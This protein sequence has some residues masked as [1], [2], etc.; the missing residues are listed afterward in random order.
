MSVKKLDDI[1]TT[2]TYAQKVKR[3]KLSFNIENF[4]YLFY[5]AFNVGNI[6]TMKDLFQA[7]VN[8]GCSFQIS[9]PSLVF[10]TNSRQQYIKMCE[11]TLAISPDYTIE[12]KDVK[13]IHERLIEI[14]VHFKGTKLFKSKGIPICSDDSEM[15]NMIQDT[16]QCKSSIFKDFDAFN[17]KKIDDD[18]L[19]TNNEV[20]RSEGICTIRYTISSELNKIV[21]YAAKLSE[22]KQMY[23]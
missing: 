22:L 6:E 7:Y 1:L 11:T 20:V 12:L 5:C 14:K 4:P 10:K 15:K 21:G 16:Y 13:R 23:K 18:M 19:V 3:R 17:M 9:R 2:N 8:P